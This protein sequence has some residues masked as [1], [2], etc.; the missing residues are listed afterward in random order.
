MINQSECQYVWRSR[1]IVEDNDMV[2]NIEKVMM[3]SQHQNSEC[4]LTLTAS[5][6]I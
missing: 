1:F 4:C 3:D 2:K 6:V 5:Q